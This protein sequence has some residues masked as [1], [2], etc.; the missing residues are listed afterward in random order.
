[1]YRDQ[2]GLVEATRGQRLFD[3]EPAAAEHET[4]EVTVSVP[5][6]DAEQDRQHWSVDDWYIE[7]CRHLERGDSDDAA[8]AFRLCLMAR[9][10]DSEINFLLAEALYRS[11]N[12]YGALERY[13]SAV[14]LDHNYI[15]AWTQLGCLHA[16]LDQ[17]DAA[18]EA[19]K[20][21]LSL[22]PDYPDAHYHSAEIL[23]QLGRND[24]AVPHWKEYLDHDNRGPWAETA[25][26]RLTE[27]GSYEG[28][29]ETDSDSE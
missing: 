19:L 2:N 27:A 29:S 9:P 26:Q 7:G 24:E 28:S 15:E 3:F 14:E 10:G 18:L 1:V 12:P 13:Y 4:D 25:R 17:P 21:A 22:H 23:S 20:I 8:E 11:E 16:E 6:P 5:Y